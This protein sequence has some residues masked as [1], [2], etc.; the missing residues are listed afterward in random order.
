MDEFERY[1]F[2]LN[3]YLL[4]KGALTRDA[5]SRC[6][7]AADIM[8][9]R[10]AS[11][12]DDEP[13]FV[14]HYGLRYHYDEELG[15]SSY[16][17]NHG[18]GGLQYV[19]D[20][21][22]NADPA[23]DAVVGHET[24]MSY[25][26]RMIVGPVKIISSELRYRHRGNITG[27]HMGGPIDARNRYSF[28]GR[29]QTASSE[30][31][32]NAVDFDLLN[33]RVLYALHDMPE[34][35]GALCVVPGS[36]KANFHSPYGPDPLKEPGMK[37]IP[38]QAGDALLF[39]ENLRHGGYPN[40]VDRTRKTLHLCFGPIWVGSQSPAHYD[41]VVHVTERAW[42]RYS[43]AQRSLLPPPS[44]MLGLGAGVPTS[45]AS[46]Q[47]MRRLQAEV[48]ELARRNAELER[49]NGQL[50]GAFRA[51]LESIAGAF[52]RALRRPN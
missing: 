17:T 30:S 41:G 15:C 27:T 26:H 14:G 3:G 19:V 4:V 12:I 48:E 50:G 51:L 37:V 28:F 22:L 9:Q 29:Q 39:T 10:I 1:Q 46:F 6:L 36:H 45:N 21:F 49:R 5:T 16:Q 24:V 23:F 32:E 20:D 42:Q 33:V 44:P 31:R 13:H 43:E 7:A 38:M 34:E 18:G 35:N 2:D 52:G 40:T 25:V 8:E 11:T 47:A